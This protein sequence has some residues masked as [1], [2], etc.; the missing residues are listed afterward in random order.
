MLDKYLKKIWSK[1][2]WFP[3]R[4]KTTNSQYLM[5]GTH[6]RY[7]FFSTL[8]VAFSVFQGSDRRCQVFGRKRKKEN[9]NTKDKLW[10][11]KLIQITKIVLKGSFSICKS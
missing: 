5:I 3:P 8:A 10:E 2:D 1:K 6:S 11:V 4:K 7:S 9:I